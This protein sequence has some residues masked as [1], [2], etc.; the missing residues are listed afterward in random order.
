MRVTNG[1]PLRSPPLT[2][3]TV[4]SVATLK[5]F[6]CFGANNEL[7]HHTDDATQHCRPAEVIHR[8]LY[9][10]SFDHANDRTGL[11]GLG[12]K[13]IVNVSAHGNTFEGS[14]AVLAFPEDIAI[15][16]GFR[17][18]TG[19]EARS[20]QA[21]NTTTSR[22][23]FASNR[24]HRT[25]RR[26]TAGITYLKIDVP[27]TVEG[28]LQPFFEKCNAFMYSARFQTGPPP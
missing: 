6:C 8:K 27:D 21:T 14:G 18:V 2:V 4:N 13:H 12:I 1:I 19:V 26:N 28:Q 17:D 7:C 9:L 20:F 25:L 11:D 15:A 5:A 16:F 3:T 24:C 22:P 10:G 23:S